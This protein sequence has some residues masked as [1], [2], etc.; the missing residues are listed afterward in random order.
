MAEECNNGEASLTE[1][2]GLDFLPP[3]SLV[4]QSDNVPG[5]EDNISVATAQLVRNIC[6]K[7]IDKSHS[8]ELDRAPSDLSEREQD[9]PGVEQEDDEKSEVTAELTYSIRYSVSNVS[10]TVESTTDIDPSQHIVGVMIGE[11]T[12]ESTAARLL[13][14]L[15]SDSVED[16]S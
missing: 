14:G 11:D 8:P 2:D 1:Q 6:Y 5:E 7:S 12:S 15:R 10:R 13:A 4:N 16:T 9:A 3:D